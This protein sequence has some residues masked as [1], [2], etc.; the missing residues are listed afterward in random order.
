[1]PEVELR[2]DG[3]LLEVEFNVAPDHGGDVL[4]A[5]YD[6]DCGRKYVLEIDTSQVATKRVVVT[7]PGGVAE[8]PEVE[9][10]GDEI[11]RRAPQLWR[12]TDDGGWAPAVGVSRTLQM[13]V[14]TNRVEELSVGW[15]RDRVRLTFHPEPEERWWEVRRQDQP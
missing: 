6:F 13:S 7:R 4:I 10:S 2:E 5:E 1:M 12:Q 8:G 9:R 11:A 3:E 15:G 14:G